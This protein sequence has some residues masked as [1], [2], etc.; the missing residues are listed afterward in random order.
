MG[1]GKTVI[2]SNK[3]QNPPVIESDYACSSL[4]TE[5]FAVD[6]LEFLQ[7]FVTCSH[8]ALFACL[9][10]RKGGLEK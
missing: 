1:K 6:G 8:S 3:A 2:K 7:P 10:L 4:W 5:Y 9:K